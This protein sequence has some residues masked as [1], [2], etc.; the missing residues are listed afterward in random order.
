MANHIRVNGGVVAGVATLVNASQSGTITPR[1]NHVRQLEARFGE[2]IRS[3]LAVEPSALTADEATYILNFRTADG[4]RDSIS[5]ARGDRE[6]R[7]L[8]KGIGSPSRDGEA[9][10]SVAVGSTDGLTVAADAKK[11]D[12][13]RD[14]AEAVNLVNRMADREA[15]R[16]AFAGRPSADG[17]RADQAAAI[18][19]IFT[20]F[21]APLVKRSDLFGLS[22]PRRRNS[23]TAPTAH[24]HSTCQ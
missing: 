12:L 19:M 24:A 9:S 13:A 18:V 21:K 23:C 8:S 10:G 22:A 20:I 5:K 3:E 1:K 16:V 17:M 7:L 15:A 2:I 14:M 11:T 4:L 6:R